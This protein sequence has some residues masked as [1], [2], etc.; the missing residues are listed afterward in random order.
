MMQDE[1]RSGETTITEAEARGLDALIAEVERR[2]RTPGIYTSQDA[3][4]FARQWQ[5]RR[6]N[7]K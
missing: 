5:A 4:E 1:K 3:T 2:V 7:A 6:A